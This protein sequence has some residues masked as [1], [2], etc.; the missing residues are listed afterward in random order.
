MLDEITN[1]ILE[2]DLFR[3]PDLDTLLFFQKTGM[4]EETV[5]KEIRQ[6][7]GQTF[8]AYL[9]DLR[10]ETLL[11]TLNKEIIFQRPGYYYQNS[12][13]KSRTPF[14]R[15]FKEKTGMNLQNYIENLKKI[16]H[17]EKV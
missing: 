8:L 16:L 5:L 14:E 1:K 13:F 12:G 3:N 15:C 9:N 17:T 2:R 6:K 4:A 7:K 10:I 11:I